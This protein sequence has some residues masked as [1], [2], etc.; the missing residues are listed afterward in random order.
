MLTRILIICSLL[1]HVESLSIGHLD[2]EALYSTASITCPTGFQI[3]IYYASFG[4]NCQATYENNVLK[5]MQDA[6]NGRNSCSWRVVD[7]YGTNFDPFY[8]CDKALDWLWMCYN[9][10]RISQ[11]KSKAL[12]YQLPTTSF[13]ATSSSPTTPAY[14]APEK[15][16]AGQYAPHYNVFRGGWCAAQNSGFYIIGCYKD[17][18]N[19]A[20]RW[21]PHNFGYT[22]D[23]CRDFCLAV[24]MQYFALQA[25]SWCSCDFDINHVIQYGV[26]T[27]CAANGGGGA[28][29]NNVYGLEYLE[30]DLG[31][32]H[33]ITG[34]DTWGRF[35]HPKECTAGNGAQFVKQYLIKYAETADDAAVDY[36]WKNFYPKQGGFFEG[37][38]D[39]NTEKSHLFVGNP[40]Y[41]R[42]VRFYP[43][44]WSVWPCMRV[45]IY[46]FPFVE[47]N[48]DSSLA[49]NLPNNNF[50]ASTF[51]PDCP[52]YYA[53]SDVAS[54]Y[55]WCAG[56]QDNNMKYK[57]LGCYADSNNRALRYGPHAYGYT[58]TS[59]RIACHGYYYFAVQHDSWCSCDND[60]NSVT[61][62]GTSSACTVHR[63][64]AAGANSIYINY[65][66][67][68]FKD[69]I[70][71]ALRYGPHE[72]GYTVDSC[73]TACIDYLYYAI[74]AT[75]W[76]SCDNDWN[77]VTKHGT[78][79]GCANG[80][81]GIGSNDVYENMHVGIQEDSLQVDLGQISQ[82]YAVSTFG[83][84]W[85]NQFVTKYNVEYS[86]DGYEY[87]LY[88]V[89]DGNTDES[90]EKKHV[91]NNYINA[92]YIKFIPKEW[93]YYNS[94][95][96]AIYGNCGATTSD[97]NECFA[98]IS[99]TNECDPICSSYSVGSICVD[100]KC[101]CDTTTG[102]EGDGIVCTPI[103]ETHYDFVT[104][105]ASNY[106]ETSGNIEGVVVN[107]DSNDA[108]VRNIYCGNDQHKPVWSALL[109]LTQDYEVLNTLND[110]GSSDQNV[111]DIQKYIQCT[112]SIFYIIMNSGR[113]SPTNSFNIFIQYFNRLLNVMNEFDITGSF[114]INSVTN[115][116]N[117]LIAETLDAISSGIPF[118]V[119]F[120]NYNN[121]QDYKNQH[122]TDGEIFNPFDHQEDIAVI[123]SNKVC[124][125]IIGNIDDILK[126]LAESDAIQDV[127]DE[128]S[129][130][131]ESFLDNDSLN[132]FSVLVGDALR[133][134]D[135]KSVA[136]M[137]TFGMQI[138]GTKG[139]RGCLSRSYN[140][141]FNL[142]G[143]EPKIFE[144]RSAY[145]EMPGT[146][147]GV[148]MNGFIYYD[149]LTGINDILSN[150]LAFDIGIAAS[151]VPFGKAQK[152]KEIWEEYSQLL[153]D[154]P[155]IGGN[156]EFLSAVNFFDNGVNDNGG[157]IN[158][159]IDGIT[160]RLSIKLAITNAASGTIY[161]EGFR[162]N[163][164]Q[165]SEEFSINILAG[166]EYR[167]ELNEIKYGHEWIENASNAGCKTVKEIMNIIF[168]QCFEQL[169]IIKDSIVE[170]GEFIVNVL[171]GIVGSI[172]SEITSVFDTIGDF[173]DGITD[174]LSNTA[175]KM[176]DEIESMIFDISNGIVTIGT[177]F[178]N[179]M[180][181]GA[182]AIVDG[183]GSLF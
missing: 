139:I 106:N 151:S 53:K 137:M 119:P 104:A 80:I 93:N 17:T 150:E 28:L 5:R 16:R 91:F 32:K 71:R 10:L 97:T 178:A 180:E 34:I 183:L 149:I 166:V 55:S 112:E 115:A 19:R 143:D 182:N 129:A 124:Q 107:T 18:G 165:G 12:V 109:S 114:D 90:N 92:R 98:P 99:D 38:A 168:N 128:F 47:S 77:H 181:S 158:M 116:I 23:S 125:K 108:T 141:L 145:V 177:Q 173:F 52:A 46:G 110:I 25:G 172:I 35:V 157:I 40:L 84:I 136:I 78:S 64:G 88:G 171:Q 33:Q 121:W 49:V 142:N 179:A 39:C 154:V 2:G 75:S 155:Y 29:L 131:I 159:L 87:N 140:V 85:H 4:D 44:S 96:V 15:S 26:G 56:S 31:S 60:V 14:H 7:G 68:C 70:D 113:F 59:C 22:H 58:V 163:I 63:I 170:A 9:P 48:S 3:D 24:G 132:I 45:E 147:L 57:Y 74:E 130:N 138:C 120:G 100:K 167:N 41:A 50:I 103:V 54:G 89:F 135:Y 117:N 76:C 101:I 42:Y 153:N 36:M 83:R 148:A 164:N 176:S 102:Y 61:Q 94:M 144:S 169:F 162:I 86:L 66:R 51:Y 175:L 69:T 43:R 122:T 13:L 126:E 156:D 20:L 37:N 67:G 118:D 134:G 160:G 30:I 81:G 127:I 146:S 152:I 133:N 8:G 123:V 82:I 111:Q 1:N 65:F 6:C 73:R 27:G 95:R 161:C 174:T 105:S 21:G 62:Y 11:A 79:T 72:Y